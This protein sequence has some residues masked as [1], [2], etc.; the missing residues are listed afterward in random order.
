MES[1]GGDRRAVWAYRALLAGLV[2]LLAAPVF[3]RATGDWEAVYLAAAKNLRS[4]A[5]LLDGG[6]GYVYPPFGALVAVPFTFLPRGAGLAAWVLVNVIAVAVML[7]GAWRLVGGRGLPG[8]R[9]T[10]RVDHAAFWLGGLCAAG[11][12]LDAAANWQTDLVIGAL[13]VGGGVLLAQGRGLSAGV[14]FG[15]AAAFKCTPLLFAPYL[16]WKRCYLGG[17]AVVVVAVGLNLLPDLA[18]PPVD[19]KPRVVVWKDR[20]LAPMADRERDPGVWAS[21]V[22]YNHSLAGVNLRWLAFDRVEVN[23]QSV[24]VPRADRISAADLKALNFALA[25]VLGLVSL[26]AL[27]RRPSKIAPGPVFAA[28]LGVVFALMLLLS[29]MSSKPHF[30]ILLLP[31]LALVRA[32]WLHR[33]RLLLALAA[34]VG[35]AGLC[36]GKDITGR[37]AYEFL[38]WNGLVFWMTVALFLGCCHARFRY[39]ASRQVAAAPPEALASRRAA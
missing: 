33:D 22:G 12:L 29:P 30:G 9:G 1:A 14:A 23:R 3:T 2:A 10:G 32:G 39:G 19:G 34:L 24:A 15:V 31:Q 7:V 35:V 18:Y 21:A 16:L 5:D 38:L 6:T 20:F 11:F 4:G 25:G 36:T 17:V 13:L 26:V 28:E 37:A 8:Q 27:W